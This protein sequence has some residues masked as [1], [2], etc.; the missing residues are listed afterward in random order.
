MV[1]LYMFL[2]FQEHVWDTPRSPFQKETNHGNFV[3]TTSTPQII[4]VCTLFNPFQ[5]SHFMSF[6]HSN[7][8]RL[9][10]QSVQGDRYMLD[11]LEGSS[12][13]VLH[14]KLHRYRIQLI[15]VPWS[16]GVFGWTCRSV[17]SKHGI[18]WMGQWRLCKKIVRRVWNGKMVVG[19]C[20]KLTLIFSLGVCSVGSDK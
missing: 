20:W 19:W 5:A 2:P 11:T 16:L 1:T 8:Q 17:H 3:G 7:L 18:T 4:Q 13:G 9:F 14:P 6:H 10:P 12:G 15:D